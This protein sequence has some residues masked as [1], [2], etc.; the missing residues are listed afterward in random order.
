MKEH[1]LDELENEAKERWGQTME[2]QESQ[3][4]TAAWGKADWEAMKA[5]QAGLMARI[6]EGMDQGPASPET[7]EAVK[8]YHRFIDSTFYPCP[9]AT[10]LGLSELWKGDE[11]F[12]ASWEGIKPGLCD[13]ACEAVQVYVRG[14]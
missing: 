6:G 9:P 7:Q 12:R 4:R 14:L 10:F 8:A 11:R 13:F 3:R 5:R 2:W 1:K